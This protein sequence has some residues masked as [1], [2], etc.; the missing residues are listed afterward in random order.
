LTSGEWSGRLSVTAFGLVPCLS[1]LSEAW[2]RIMPNQELVTLEGLFWT[3]RI[4]AESDMPFE[5]SA[6]HP[7]SAGRLYDINTKLSMLHKETD[8]A[9]AN[10]IRP[11][12]TA[13]AKRLLAMLMRLEETYLAESQLRFGH[14]VESNVYAY[15]MRNRDAAL[16]LNRHRKWDE[17]AMF[18]DSFRMPREVIP[19]HVSG[20]IISD[21]G[22]SVP[23]NPTTRDEWWL[24][25]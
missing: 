22:I 6:S 1:G 4:D 3:L 2:R 25:A 18:I 13:H 5:G 9:D 23:G 14:A 12:T 16:V 15:A 17:M 10:M 19:N 7:H 11:E 24:G 20:I 21:N 8:P